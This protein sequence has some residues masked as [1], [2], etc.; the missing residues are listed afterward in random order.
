[1]RNDAL[2]SILVASNAGHASHRDAATDFTVATVLAGNSGP[3]SLARWHDRVSRG[4]AGLGSGDQYAYIRYP[5][6]T[7][8]L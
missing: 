8:G 6:G 7:M 2:D 5:D 1:M 4:S 3:E